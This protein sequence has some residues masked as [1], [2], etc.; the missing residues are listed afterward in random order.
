MAGERQNIA[1]KRKR[2]KANRSKAQRP[3]LRAHRL[4]A[5]FLGLWGAALGG[6]TTLVLPQPMVL[7]AAA[8]LGLGV[9]GGLA[10][11]VLAVLAA[12]ILGAGMLVLARRIAI[13]PQSAPPAD[14]PSLAVMAMRHVRTIDPIKDLGSDSLDEPVQSPPF[15][16]LRA[17]AERQAEVAQHDLPPPQALDLG[18]FAMLGGRNAVWV[19]EPAPAAAEAAQPAQPT[20]I[21]DTDPAPAP[22]PAPEPEPEREPASAPLR[23]VSPTAVERLRAV[24]PSELSLVQ[25]V[26]RFA[27]A[28]HEHQAAAPQEGDRAAGSVRDAALAE[29]LKTLATL[30]QGAREDTHS[31]PLHTAISRLQELRGAA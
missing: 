24:P 16:S 21:G 17:E 13:A 31:E 19:E 9:L 10:P 3:L 6:L 7:A 29:A 26:E 4:F 8:A 15:A 30:S 11:F 27:A 18:E 12:L 22:E 14:A 2:G 28:M 20:V 1:G 23:T 5:P 25:M